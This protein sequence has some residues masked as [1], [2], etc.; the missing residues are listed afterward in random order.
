MLLNVIKS[1]GTLEVYLHTKVMG[2]I[3]AALGDS[4]CETLGIT[5]SLAEALTEFISRRHNGST[6][7]TDEIHA[8]I[9]AVLSETDYEDAALCLHE[10]RLNRQIKRS[11]TEVIYVN[12]D[13]PK[14][15]E[16]EDYDKYSYPAQ[17]WNKSMIVRTLEG[18]S[19]LSRPMARAVAGSVEEKVLRIGSRQIFSSLIRELVA[20]E[21]WS[22][23]KAELALAPQDTSDDE[24]YAGCR[25]MELLKA[26]SV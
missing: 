15:W 13:I 1:D 22:I 18:E 5:D 2:T 26:T 23:R 25:E 7:S 3:A 16:A 19:G 6:I 4:G 10:H 14:P 9:K 12:G 20:N 24:D 17:P 11:R 21:L 8:M